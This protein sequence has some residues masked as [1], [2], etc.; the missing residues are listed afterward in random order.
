M[1]RTVSSHS[2]RCGFCGSGLVTQVCITVLVTQ[3][4]PT[5][6]GPMDCISPGSSLQGFLQA[7]TLE[8]VAIPS[9]RW[10][11]QPRERTWVSSTA[12]RFLTIWATREVN[13]Y[14]NDPLIF[15]KWQWIFGSLTIHTMF[16]IMKIKSFW[17]F[18][19]VR[20][21]ES[22]RRHGFFSPSFPWLRLQ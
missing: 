8:W 13:M 15:K 20:A 1:K 14:D 11:S 12:G 2:S 16:H 21:W 3:S 10:P 22:W 9:S 4:C 17:H 6:C 19:Q 5:L 18:R 7:R